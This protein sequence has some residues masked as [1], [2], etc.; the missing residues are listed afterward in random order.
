[1]QIGQ[2]IIRL[3]TVDSTNN[4]TANLIKQGKILPGAVIMADEQTAGKGQRGAVWSSNAGE[5]LLLSVFLNSANLSLHQQVALTHFAAVSVMETLRKIGISAQIKWPNDIFVGHRKIAGIL[6]E[7]AIVDGQISHSILGIG[8]N[9]NQMDFKD[10]S[11][12]S[13]KLEKMTFY[14]V[15]DF[16]FQLIFVL[17]KYWELLKNGNLKSLRSIY[18]DNLYLLEQEAMFE[19]ENGIFK[20]TIQ[21]ISEEGLLTIQKVVNAE[22]ILRNYDLKEVKFILKSGL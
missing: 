15:E 1:M 18:L 12:T 3:D 22:I 9:V 20:G 11:A 2:K 14:A 4:Y 16:L 6:I 10:L 21:G 5:N 13:V 8:L 17:N 19:D 7:N